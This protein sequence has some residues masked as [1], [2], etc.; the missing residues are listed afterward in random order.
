[1][2]PIASEKASF[3]RAYRPKNMCMNNEKFEK[4]LGVKLPN[5][6]DLIHSIAKEYNEIT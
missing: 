2:M 4:A 3:L 6:I 5:L 1:M